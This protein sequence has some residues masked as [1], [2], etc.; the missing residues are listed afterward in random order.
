ML[1]KNI[2][3]RGIFTT[4]LFIT[5]GTS[6]VSLGV[7]L[8]IRNV[9]L[10]EGT[11]DIY[12]SNAAACSYC[13]DSIYNNNTQDWFGTSGQKEDCESF[14]DTTW[15]AYD[16]ITEEECSAIPSYDGNGGWWFDG[17]VAG[18]QFEISGITM[19]G[20]SGGE[21]EANDF[22]LSASSN[23]VLGFSTSGTVIPPGSHILSQITFSNYDGG[24]ICFGTNPIN[25]IVSNPYGNSLQ[26]EWGDCAS[27]SFM[28][29]LNNDG[30]LDILDLVALANLILNEE[31]DLNGDMNGDGQLNILDIVSLVNTI[32]G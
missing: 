16:P 17:H 13:P 5:M 18:F 25:N 24:E 11:L 3:I 6:Q 31:F 2:A 8:E 23:M 7:S 14:G 10:E 29:D 32:L 1:G 28:G 30:S 4:I 26:T 19:T 9:K 22:V 12:M 21:A 20:I 27:P 15:V